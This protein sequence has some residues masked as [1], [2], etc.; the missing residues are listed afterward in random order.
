M[1]LKN[2]NP[3]MFLSEAKT[4]TK[5]NGTKRNRLLSTVVYP[6]CL[7]F[8]YFTACSFKRLGIPVK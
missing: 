7:V 5:K 3:E 8:T 6:V 1:H 4:G 2:L